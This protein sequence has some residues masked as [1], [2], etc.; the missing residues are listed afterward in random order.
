[1]RTMNIIIIEKKLTLLSYIGS[2]I[3]LELILHSFTL[4]SILTFSN[5]Q[6]K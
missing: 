2:N 1:M 4:S 5:I 6:T 3:K